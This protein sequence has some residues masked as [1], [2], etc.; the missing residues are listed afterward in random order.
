MK[1]LLYAAVIMLGTSTYMHSQQ[2][3][4]QNSNILEQG[5]SAIHN[6]LSTT[7]PILDA[8]KNVHDGKQL[9][10]PH[11]IAI[12]SYIKGT[13][14]NIQNHLTTLN[15]EQK[16]VFL[17]GLVQ[18]AVEIF[19]HHV[20]QERMMQYVHHLTQTIRYII[21]FG[22]H[23]SEDWINFITSM[24]QEFLQSLYKESPPRT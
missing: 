14:T 3:P 9:Q 19:T 5:A 2:A 13:I 24:S 18:Q 21:G 20:P 4:M 11:A 22:M 6:I 8:Y 10:D 1:K 16:Q 17:A 23:V 15:E 12:G 7:M